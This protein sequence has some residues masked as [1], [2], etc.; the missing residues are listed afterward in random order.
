MSPN[1]DVIFNDTREIHSIHDDAAAITWHIVGTNGVT[2]IEAY[3]EYGSLDFTP[4]LAI[5]K[6]DFLAERRPAIG[7]R[8]NYKEPHQGRGGGDV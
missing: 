8:I 3:K 2:K 1:D 4:Y 6:G 7:L 5:W